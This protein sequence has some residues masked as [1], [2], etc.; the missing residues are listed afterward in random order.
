MDDS[1]YYL[2]LSKSEL[3]WKFNFIGFCTLIKSDQVVSHLNRL[4]SLNRN[5]CKFLV[6]T[7]VNVLTVSDI[8]PLNVAGRHDLLELLDRRYM[9][10][11]TAFVSQLPVEQWHA[12]IGD[13]TLADAILDRRIHNAFRIQR[14][15]ESM[16]SKIKARELNRTASEHKAQDVQTQPAHTA[17]EE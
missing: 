1:P 6:G 2:R 15:G 9:R 13:A 4:E 3:R 7:F 14:K 12:G 5:I 16:S 11:S 8:Q 10:T 17:R